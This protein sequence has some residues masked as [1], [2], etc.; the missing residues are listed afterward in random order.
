[1]VFKSFHRQDAKF[2]KEEKTLGETQASGERK[3]PDSREL[4]NQIL[5][6]YGIKSPRCWSRR[7]GPFEPSRCFG[8]WVSSL[9]TA[10]TP[11]SRR[12]KRHWGKPRRAWGGNPMILEETSPRHIAPDNQNPGERGV[13]P[14]DSWRSPHWALPAT[15]RVARCLIITHD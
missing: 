12:K 11:S 9:F 15:L 1:M 10:K 6:S 3:L 5:V 4:R 7:K 8:K 2:A 13:A 14:H